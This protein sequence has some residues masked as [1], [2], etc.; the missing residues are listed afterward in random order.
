MGQRCVVGH[1]LHLNVS[2]LFCDSVCA[3]NQS[4]TL[5]LPGAVPHFRDC[6]TWK[7]E[8]RCK[9][10]LTLVCRSFMTLRVRVTCNGCYAG[11]LLF[12]SYYWYVLRAVFFFLPTLKE[13][14]LSTTENMKPM[15]RS[16]HAIC[17]EKEHVGHRVCWYVLSALSVP[18]NVCVRTY[19]MNI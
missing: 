13:I 1:G 9:G 19:T 5:V 7:S 16:L 18:D 17:C 10:E 2:V 12:L 11:L 14:K 15:D 3:G 8:L 4:G 6:R